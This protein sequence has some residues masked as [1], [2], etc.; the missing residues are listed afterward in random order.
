M[1]SEPDGP[2]ESKVAPNVEIAKEPVMVESPL[3]A[4]F[5]I[6]VPALFSTSTAFV[7]LVVPE[8]LTLNEFEDAP[9]IV[10]F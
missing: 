7:A 10:T 2:R 9:V 4:I 3:S 5:K 8:P 1:Y 6:E